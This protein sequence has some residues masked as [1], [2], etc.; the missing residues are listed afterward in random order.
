MKLQLQSGKVVLRFTFSFIIH[1]FLL[2]CVVALPGVIALLNPSAIHNYNL[3]GFISLLLYVMYCLFYGFYIAR[4][5]AEILMLIKKIAK[6]DFL[7]VAVRKTLFSRRLYREVFENL[8]QLTQQLQ[9]TERKREE[10]EI[11]RRNWAA[12]ITH[13]LKT[14]L[15]Y[16]KGY[17]DM[18]ITNEY[19]WTKEEQKEFLEIIHDK[20]VH[21]ES[22]INDLGLAF[23]MEESQEF[24]IDHTLIDL[25]ELIRQ[26]VA[27][28]A[29]MPQGLQNDFECMF[30][31][32][33][34]FINGDTNLLK[35]AFLNILSNAVT[36]N[37]NPIKV[38][39]KV[40]SANENV[41]ISIKDNG[42][43]MNENDLEHLFERYYRGTTTEKN[44]NATGL[45][46]AI[47]KQIVDLHNGSIEVTSREHENTTFKISLPL[48]E[49]HS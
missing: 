10:F 18:L 9:E 3:L 27:E 5:M 21:M 23:H 12:G 2:M 31:E 38:N 6:K 25:N 49:R 15:A 48:Q 7:T 16:I 11:M 34:I 13:D 47:V 28:V 40:K 37:E 35:R 39:I 24:P 19:E 42:K 30:D 1:Q 43:G 22:L 26:I 20:T 36:H 45:G 44:S 29:N 33:K 17:T 4:P 41:V 8:H 32:E 46:M 14:P